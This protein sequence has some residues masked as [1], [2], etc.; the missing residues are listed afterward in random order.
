MSTAVFFIVLAACAAVCCIASKSSMNSSD[1]KKEDNGFPVILQLILRLDIVLMRI[2]AGRVILVN[3]FTEGRVAAKIATRQSRIVAFIAFNSQANININVLGLK[4]WLHF[5][6]LISFLS[7]R[8]VLRLIVDVCM[9]S[10]S[11][12]LDS[13]LGFECVGWKKNRPLSFVTREEHPNNIPILLT[14]FEHFDHYLLL[15]GFHKNIH[16]YMLDYKY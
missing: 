9:R 7:K 2:I 14:H 6:K 12:L 1:N 4:A 8:V 11:H 3:A 10:R 16:Q 5:R 13:R 15:C